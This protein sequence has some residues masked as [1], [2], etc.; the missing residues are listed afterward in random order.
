MNPELLEILKFKYK[1]SLNAT[2]V[3]TLSC[4]AE[5][6]GFFVFVVFFFL[7]LLFAFVFDLLRFVKFFY[8][9]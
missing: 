3:S 6:A 8:L 4:L 2:L 1:S 5:V 7:F 9:F